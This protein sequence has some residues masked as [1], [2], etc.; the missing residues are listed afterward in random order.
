MAMTRPDTTI[1]NWQTVY[2][3]LS[4]TF[5]DMHAERDYLTKFVFPELREWCARRRLEF[6]DIDLRWGITDEDSTQNHRT[7]AICL[8]NVERC[9]PLFLALLGQRRGWVPAPNEV[10]PG[11]LQHYP[12]LAQ[13]IGL[14]S[15]TEL[16]IWKAVHDEQIR[17]IFFLRDP[18]ALN[19]MPDEP[20]FRLN[21]RNAALLPGTNTVVPNSDQEARH[22]SF[23][24][25]AATQTRY[26]ALTYTARWDSSLPMPEMRDITVAGQVFPRLETGRLTDF[27]CGGAPWREVVLRELKKQITAAFPDH[28]EQPP[29]RGLAGELEVQERHLQSQSDNYL[30]L[31]G[32][33]DIIPG[34]A[35]YLAVFALC[36]AAGSG[37]SAYLANYIRKQDKQVYYRFCGISQ[38]SSRE[39]ELLYSLAEQWQQDGRLSRLPERSQFPA[40][41][42]MLFREA[43]RHSPMTVVIDGLDELDNGEARLN[44]C[45]WARYPDCQGSRLLLSVKQG[46]VAAKRL[47]AFQRLTSLT[48]LDTPQARRA[49]VEQKLRRSLKRLEPDQLDALCSAPHADNPLFLSEVLYE[50]GLHGNRS[51]LPARLQELLPLD[52]AGVAGKIF[53]RLEQ[54]PAYLDVEQKPFLQA[55][56]GLLGDARF[57]LTEDDLADILVGVKRAPNKEMALAAVRYYARQLRPFLIWRGGR[58]N[59]LYATWHALCRQRY[60]GRWHS[61][62]A[63]RFFNLCDAQSSGPYLGQ[64]PLPFR[65]FSYH[66]RF[67]GNQRM[68]QEVPTRLA[69]S[70]DWV[71]VKLRLCGARALLEEV[72]NGPEAVRQSGLP[73]FYRD[74]ETLLDAD[75]DSLT[76][77][78]GTHMD[79]AAQKDALLDKL[80]WSCAGGANRMS[81]RP[82]VAPRVSLYHSAETGWA[83]RWRLPPALGKVRK[84]ESA[85]TMLLLETEDGQHPVLD[86]Q[87]GE[88]LGTLPAGA[89]WWPEQHCFYAWDPHFGE[90]CTYNSSNLTAS[91]LRGYSTDILPENGN[92]PVCAWGNMLYF[93]ARRDGKEPLRLYAQERQF[94]ARGVVQ[95]SRIVYNAPLDA[96]PD[97]IWMTADS[98]GCVLL[99]LW[100]EEASL[101]Y[102]DRE[103]GTARCIRLHI[104]AAIVQATINP[105][106]ALEHRK[107]RL[108]PNRPG[109]LLCGKTLWLTLRLPA[110]SPGR[111]ENVKEEGNNTQRWHDSRLYRIDLTDIRALQQE[112][113]RYASVLRLQDGKLYA[114]ENF[115]MAVIAGSSECQFADLA[116]YTARNC[117]DPVT[118]QALE[119]PSVS[120]LLCTDCPELTAGLEFLPGAKELKILRREATH[121]QEVTTLYGRAPVWTCDEGYLYRL[122]QNGCVERY[123]LQRL[124]REHDAKAGL[125]DIFVD[126]QG[127]WQK[128][129]VPAG[130][131]LYNKDKVL[132][133]NGC[134]YLIGTLDAWNQFREKRVS[135]FRWKENWTDVRMFLFRRRP[136]L[137][138]SQEDKDFIL[139]VEQISTD[140]NRL[141]TESI[142]TK[143]IVQ[144]GGYTNTYADGHQEH[145]P[146]YQIATSK[147]FRLRQ[148]LESPR[149]TWLLTSQP[150]N[151]LLRHPL[152]EKQKIE[153]SGSLGVELCQG[154]ALERVAWPKERQNKCW[155]LLRCG[156]GTTFAATLRG[157][158]LYLSLAGPRVI[159]GNK[160]GTR[161]LCLH[162]QADPEIL[163][164]T[165][166]WVQ[167]T[168][169]AWDDDLLYITRP[170]VNGRDT[171]AYGCRVGVNRHLQPDT[172]ATLPDGFARIR[173]AR[174]GVLLLV[175][176][177]DTGLALFR[178]RDCKVVWQMNFDAVVQDV[179]WPCDDSI[180]LQYLLDGQR[181]CRLS[182]LRP[183]SIWNG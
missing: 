85:G 95:S 43:A 31:P 124:T 108:G 67:C 34:P 171:T 60:G 26:P 164:Q 66:T 157:E 72:E 84:M 77:V 146:L 172:H 6:V 133:E 105:Q 177:D 173:A 159:D 112:P 129:W 121:C 176:D 97:H 61:A 20:E 160:A 59:F 29:L 158:D 143:Q 162:P 47:N 74:C 15:I 93:A 130:L 12:D 35:R 181:A 137:R 21:Y 114:Y 169:L 102:L 138:Y 25:W 132:V 103:R 175:A 68:S 118:G 110:N 91:Y 83:G 139:Y 117:Y 111:V 62:L 180:R 165:A 142:T 70:C 33:Y 81:S 57:G 3:F 11:L 22:E 30:E 104:P 166:D 87:T 178:M 44:W 4:S 56:F 16:E 155:S 13:Q 40:A 7:L 18:A 122:N 131:T 161:I 152:S 73:A 153:Q 148:V 8:E 79:K 125:A 9:R 58:L 174:H 80:F 17:G 107:M 51:T 145:V 65:E 48:L 19:G 55:M 88:W 140:T 32:Q 149:Y 115:A 141:V 38:D 168:S 41:F 23:R 76:Q 135:S 54:D 134:G 50:L 92:I 179:S 101:Y 82:L 113:V 78:L 119:E 52:A 14:R 86:K 116:Y 49:L 126:D 28:T 53:D 109:M 127:N 183:E 96:S 75:P 106:V 64:E 45:R 94:D 69:I 156:Y 154:P 182:F 24:S 27:T 63:F 46:T 42:P 128:V 10:D 98:Q 2:L 163:W 167:Q 136:L 36:A 71:W 123:D 170:A 99:G 37:K 1:Q 5:N 90:F 150:G 39:S 144:V 120:P 89:R 147:R 100:G 151:A